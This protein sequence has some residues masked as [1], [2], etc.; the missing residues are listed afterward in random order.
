MGHGR[1]RGPV[2]LFHCDV[3]GSF[4]FGIIEL[5][6]HDVDELV[7]MCTYLIYNMHVVSVDC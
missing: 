5:F 6:Y 1:S 3:I 4:H 7:V 2:G